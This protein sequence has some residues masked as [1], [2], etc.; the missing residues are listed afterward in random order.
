MRRMLLLAILPLLFCCKKNTCGICNCVSYA[1]TICAHYPDT[2]TA[3]RLILGKWYLRE[4]DY[5]S[6]PLSGGAS[7]V[8]YY[9]DTSDYLLFLANDS[10]IV[11][12]KS[13]IE[14]GIRIKPYGLIS[15]NNLYYGLCITDKY[16]IYDSLFNIAVDSL[17]NTNY[18]PMEICNR[19]LILG[20]F[21]GG[22]PDN[23]YEIIFT[24]QL[25]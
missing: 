20:P 1:D 17:R 18:W 5:P 19:V 6:P 3:N 11:S 12:N 4:M 23:V 13:A 16:S 10:V 7:G 2:A 9:C 8:Q 24:R 22:D 25:Q 21:P 14:P 15:Y